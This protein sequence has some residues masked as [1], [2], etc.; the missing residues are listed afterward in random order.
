MRTISQP[1][2]VHCKSVGDSPRGLA[3]YLYCSHTMPMPAPK[4]IYNFN[5]AQYKVNIINFGAKKRHRQNI[6]FSRPK[7]TSGCRN[8]I[9]LTPNLG[10]QYR[11]SGVKVAPPPR[12]N[13][14]STQ[15]RSVYG[16]WPRR[17]LQDGVAADKKG[18]SDHVWKRFSRSI[19][20][21]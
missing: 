13:P 2:A 15:K 19:Q 7:S 8:K 1:F 17:L 11:D 20:G 21:I 9:P 14:I 6:S 3:L 18:Y 4:A 10:P 5:S 16:P 12:G